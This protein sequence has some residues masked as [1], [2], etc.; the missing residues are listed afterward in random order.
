[1]SN[2]NKDSIIR[3]LQVTGIMNRGGAETLIMNLYRA[4]DRNKIQFDFVE[5]SLKPGEFDKE[6]ESLGGKIYYCPH[7]NG[8]NHF[9]YCRWWKLFWKKN[10]HK[11][12]VVHGHIGST[13]AIYLAIAKQHGAY[14][15]AHSHGMNSIHFLSM[16]RYQAFYYPTRWISDS[17]FSCSLPAGIDRFGK[18]VV[19]DSNRHYVFPN[20]IDT[21]VF[22]FSPKKR[23]EMRRVLKIQD[24]VLTIGHVGRFSAEKN[25]TFL[26]EIAAELKS[27]CP[28]LCVLLVGDGYLRQEMEQKAV[29]LGIGDVVRFL[30][31]RDDVASLMQAMDVLVFPSISEGFGVTLIEA[32]TSGLP[33]VISDRIPN[34]SWVCEDLIFP[35]SVND[36]PRKWADEIYRIRS[37]PRR[38][39]ASEV[40]EAGFDIKRTAK[41]LEDYYLEKAKR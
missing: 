33:C 38:D 4:V 24:H 5:N 10:E 11:Y 21:K 26:L 29:E 17:F 30:G 12:P 31:V 34:E 41:W 16:I 37:A 27:F 1:M 7:Y 25:H 22:S 18:R 32:Q 2:Q 19:A 9:A 35:L 28:E 39:H 6:I 3:I 23:E 15:I 14:T 20:S 40:S 13:A 36:S 8:K